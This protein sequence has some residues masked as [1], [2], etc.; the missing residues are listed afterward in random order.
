MRTP[1]AVLLALPGLSL[2]V[3]GLF[4]PM[5]LGYGTARTWWVLHVLGMF[6]FPLVGVALAWLFRGR[7]DVVAVLAVLLAYVYAVAYTALDMISGVAAGYVT[8]RL[9]PGRP[10]PD[11]VR[12]LFA[13][14]GPLGEW[15]SRALMLAALLVA[16][17]ALWRHRS[18]ALPGVLLLPGAYLVHV[19]H[20]FAPEGVTGMVLIGLATGWLGYLQGSPAPPIGRTPVTASRSTGP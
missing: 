11:E 1:R 4:H 3:A 18:R 20:I 19:H 10:R 6:V 5:H 13:I 16:A 15:G 14:G 9:G 2:G 8:D 7:R 17:D 12:Y